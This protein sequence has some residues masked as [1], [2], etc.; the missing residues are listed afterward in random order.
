M[1]KKKSSLQKKKASKYANQAHTAYFGMPIRVGRRDGP[2]QE[3]NQSSF[4]FFSLPPHTQ[5]VGYNRKKE[6][7]L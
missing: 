6:R 2:S 5:K 3:P 4:L 7:E 1:N